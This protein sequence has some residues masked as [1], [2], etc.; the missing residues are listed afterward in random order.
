MRRGGQSI[1][2]YIVHQLVEQLGGEIGV[3]ST[4]G[5]GSTFRVRLPSLAREDAAAARSA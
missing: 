1:G 3:D 5:G 2:L 4:P